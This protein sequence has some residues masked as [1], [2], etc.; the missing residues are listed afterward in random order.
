MS[1]KEKHLSAGYHWYPVKTKDKIMCITWLCSL[2]ETLLLTGK[3]IAV[4]LDY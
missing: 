4:W 3:D 1:S 2:R